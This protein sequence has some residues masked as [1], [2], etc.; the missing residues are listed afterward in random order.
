MERIFKYCVEHPKL[1]NLVL[2]LV[3]IMGSLSFFGLK[4]DSIPNVDFKMMFIT[5]VYPGASPEDVEINVTIPVE[6]KI[7]KVAGIKSMDSYSAENFSTIFVELDPDVKNIEEVKRDVYKAVDRVSGLPKEVKDKPLVTE[8]KSE[9]FPVF[10]VALTSKNGISELELRKYTKNLEDK[11]KLLPGVGG[12]KKIGYRKREVHV[13]VDPKKADQQYVSLSEI[14]AAV[15]QTNVRVSG[16]TLRSMSDKEKI[17]TLS[18]FNDPMEVKDVI[19]RSSFSG[20]RVIISE[21]SEVKDD[22]EEELRIVKANGEQSINI[23]VEKKSSADAVRVAAEVKKLLKEYNKNLPPGVY[24]QIVKD[25]SVYVNSMLSVVVS[26]AMVGF[27]LVI[28][29]LMIF[30]DWRVAFWTA[31]GI[32]FSI[33]VAFYF[34]PI[35]DVVVTTQSLLAFIIVLGMLVDDAIVVAENIYSYRERGLSA[36]EAS[37]KGVKEVFWPVFAT[38]ATTVA[39]FLPI[40]LMGGI[41]GDF[42][43]AIPIVI[44]VTL[45]ASLFESVFILPCHLAHTK[46]KKKERSKLIQRLEQVYRKN[47]VKVLHKKGRV[48]AFFVIVLIVCVV[49]IRPLLGFQLMPSTDEDIIHV[50]METPK[51]SLMRE[52]EKKVQGIERIIKEVVPEKVL[53]S[54]VTTIGEKGTDM[55][56]TISGMTQSHWAR[57]TINLI[58]AQ[59]RKISSQQIS[60]QLNQKLEPLKKSGDFTDVSVVQM[61]GGPPTGTPIDIIFI[62]NNDELRTK[63]GDELEAFIKKEPA[64]F[65]I[66]RDDEK[67]LREL[68]IKLDYPLMAKL[69]I[70]AADVASVVRAAVTGNIVTSIRKEGEE[71]DFRVM[72]EEK[73]RNDAKYIKNL[74]IPNRLGKLIKIGGFIKFEEGTSAL[75]IPHKEGD[76][77]L[78]IRAEI[79]EKKLNVS[80]YNQV[81]KKKFEKKVAQH[82]S[83]RVE[84]GGMEKVTGESLQNFFNA[85]IIALIIIYII[86]VVLFNS[87]T[88]PIIVMLAIPFGLIGVIFA[89]AIHREPI[90][91]LGLIGILG[92][93]GVVVNNSLVMLKFLNMKEEKT[94]EAGEELKIEQIADAAMLRFR[95]IV[96]TTITTV[97]GLL[98]SLYGLF[99][100]RVDF[101]FPLL[102]ALTWGLVFSS[103]ITLFLIPAFYMVERE[104]GCWFYGK[105]GRQLNK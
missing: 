38:V 42:I 73:Y 37:V 105:F 30:L 46:L 78:R 91:F 64:V 83:L 98:P 33:L 36:V 82:P 11:I 58:P 102:L 10:E 71:I 60:K 84:F 97:A 77:S 103:F 35:Y 89:F 76:R 81:L 16:G 99:G 67:G 21:V 88:E 94:C 25:Y 23:V 53:A 87:F 92:L 8:L 19:I 79:D 68:N 90:S 69:G 12:T 75:G 80:A 41:W 18:Q 61:R 52:T 45:L 13:A 26:N 66:R 63:F 43:R 14:M 85:M 44:T 2:V 17:I 74:T 39:A 7:Q 31:L 29:C 100:G 72:L 96:L 24:S 20:D 70:T 56:D 55:W 47:L 6:E 51:G 5:T 3:L 22:F 62:G 34:M 54:Y 4:R 104:V 59:Q 93:A 86:L 15:A 27:A 32:P 50:R 49:V 57:I 95:P 40:L 1:V 48:I 65:D 101:L 28:L 9:I